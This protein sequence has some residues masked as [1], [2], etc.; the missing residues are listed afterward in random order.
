MPQV[1]TGQAIHRVG[2]THS[3]ALA[4][5]FARPVLGRKQ[6]QADSPPCWLRVR[7]A[8]ACLPLPLICGPTMAAEEEVPATSAD[9]PGPSA[10]SEAEAEPGPAPAAANGDPPSSALR[11]PKRPA[12]PDETLHKTTVD[13]LAA[14]IAANKQRLQVIALDTGPMQGSWPTARTVAETVSPA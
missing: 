1:R 10:V 7:H 5:S 13:K 8:G 6:R 9:V 12:K 4:S 2:C 14:A 3:E 11:P